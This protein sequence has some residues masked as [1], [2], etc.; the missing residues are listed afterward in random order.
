MAIT[1]SLRRD[2]G[3]QPVTQRAQPLPR[4][5]APIP[6]INPSSLE[7]KRA[8]RKYRN[9]MISLPIFLV[10]S[11]FLFDRLVLGHEPKK[12]PSKRTTLEMSITEQTKD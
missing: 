6:R 3:P 8:A 2:A 1:P 10:T 12:L 5:A 11:W 4:P 7:Y 9:L